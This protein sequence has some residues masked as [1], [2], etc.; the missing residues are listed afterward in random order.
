LESLAAQHTCEIHN[1]S[2]LELFDK[3]SYVDEADFD[4]FV[5]VEILE[6]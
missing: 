1:I 4:L 5:N 2:A 3:V 6:R